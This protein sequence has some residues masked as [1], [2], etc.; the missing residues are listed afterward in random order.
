MGTAFAKYNIG[1][2]TVTWYAHTMEGIQSFA[3][4]NWSEGDCRHD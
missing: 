2:M 3:R 4:D 1:L